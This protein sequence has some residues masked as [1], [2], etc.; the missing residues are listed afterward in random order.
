MFT[1]IYN[2]LYFINNVWGS[3]SQ[4]F[5]Q[6]NCITIVITANMLMLSLV[7]VSDSTDQSMTGKREVIH[8]INKQ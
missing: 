3:L 2:V 6:S 7:S 5:V 4:C 1:L 8:F